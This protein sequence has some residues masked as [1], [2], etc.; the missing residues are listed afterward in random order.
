[1]HG[2]ASYAEQVKSLSE[3]GGRTL[4]NIK[5]FLMELNSFTLS[6]TSRRFLLYE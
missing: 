6:T 4:M 2:V 5:E 3:K 1:M